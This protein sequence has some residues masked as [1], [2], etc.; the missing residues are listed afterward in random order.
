MGVAV[1]LASA[2][3]GT[4]RHARRRDRGQ[5]AGKKG[6]APVAVGVLLPIAAGCVAF[7]AI[8][9]ACTDAD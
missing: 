4:L 7:A 6:V 9:T 1:V 2:R 8:L 5:P 3:A